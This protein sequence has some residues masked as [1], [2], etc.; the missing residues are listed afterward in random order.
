MSVWLVR[1]TL[2]LNQ[3]WIWMGAVALFRVRVYGL[4]RIPP[5]GVLLA[6]NHQSLFDPMLVGT[7]VRR[8]I[9]YM[10]RRDLFKNPLFGWLIRR[11]NTFPVDRWKADRAAI[12]TAVE[13]LKAGHP[14][15]VFPEGT[16]S[17]TGRPGV[18]SGGIRL[19]AR[20]AGV[21]VVPVRIEGAFACWPPGK[22]LPRPGRMNILFGFPVAPDRLP[23]RD[24]FILEQW[25]ALSAAPHRRI[26][27]G[28]RE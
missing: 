26:R 3:P 5:G 17:R 10:A 24:E 6:C 28:V 18:P 12:R 9:H 2:D 8:P 4:A 22:L 16:R 14:V 23:D 20:M 1:T 15:L 11:L 7:I 13:R 21:P 27:E 25:Q 19:I